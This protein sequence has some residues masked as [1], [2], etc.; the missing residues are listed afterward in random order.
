MNHQPTR[1]DPVDQDEQDL[2]VLELRPERADNL[3]RLDRFVAQAVPDLSRSYIQQLIADGF[4]LVDGQPRRP[5]FKMTYGEVVTVA[6]P[7]PADLD[8][9]PED[10]PLAVVYED[11]DVLVIDK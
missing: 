11:A 6:E 5:A 3:T 7:P 10:I 8:L 9:I 4:I 2:D 1:Q